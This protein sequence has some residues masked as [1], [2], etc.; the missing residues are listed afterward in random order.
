MN[1]SATNLNRSNVDDIVEV[2]YPNF[3]K[4]LS[5]YLNTKQLFKISYSDDFWLLWDQLNYFDSGFKHNRESLLDW[6]KDDM[7][8]TVQ[9]PETVELFHGNWAHILAAKYLTSSCHMS[10]PC[11]CAAKNGECRGVWVQE[12]LRK[13]GIAKFMLHSLGVNRI[14]RA[15]NES[16]SFWVH[17][18][19]LPSQL[20]G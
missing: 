20:P 14:N 10:L 2:L 19:M 17:M 8:Y 11:F 12:D 5:T 7:L 16:K 6:Y 15:V 9:I 4:E 3:E 13:R 1:V 18:G